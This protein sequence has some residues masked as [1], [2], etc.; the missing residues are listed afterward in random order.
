MSRPEPL[1]PLTMPVPPPHKTNGKRRKNSISQSVIAALTSNISTKAFKT[2]AQRDIPLNTI[3]PTSSHHQDIETPTSPTARASTSSLNSSTKSSYSRSSNP[4]DLQRMTSMKS[5]RVHGRGGHGS[6]PRTI[7]PTPSRHLDAQQ[8]TP[9]RNSNTS[10]SQPSYPQGSGSSNHEI[11]YQ[12]RKAPPNQNK[13]APTNPVP[14]EGD[15]VRLVGRGGLGSKPKQKTVASSSKGK[16][17]QRESSISITHK[18]S[19]LT[20]SRPDPEPVVVRFSGRGGAGSRPRPAKVEITTPPKPTAQSPPNNLPKLRWR[21]RGKRSKLGTALQLKRPST[22]PDLRNP[23]IPAT[24]AVPKA[25]S[26]INND[27]NTVNSFEDSSSSHSLPTMSSMHFRPGSPIQP[28]DLLRQAHHPMTHA[29]GPSSSSLTYNY[30]LFGWPSATANT[31]ESSL[32]SGP[33]EKR[34]DGHSLGKLSKMLGGPFSHP[35]PTNRKPS[36]DYGRGSPL[37]TDRRSESITSSSRM[38]T[39]STFLRSTTS[40]PISPTASQQSCS[41]WDANDVHQHGMES[42]SSL[43]T[44]SSSQLGHVASTMGQVRKRQASPIR[45]SDKL[46]TEAFVKHDDTPDATPSPTPIHFRSRSSTRT[47]ARSRSASRSSLPSQEESPT[48][49]SVVETNLGG[50]TD[51]DNDS[52]T[53]N[54]HG[55]SRRRMRQTWM[56]PNSTATVVEV[57]SKG[58]GGRDVGWVGQWNTDNMQDVI[59]RLRELR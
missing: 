38:E 29:H 21:S 2:T 13:V 16:Q 19:L 58:K 20:V 27:T 6:R 9:P 3:S 32:Y 31:S 45:F 22:S 26:S 52:L 48:V 34:R 28:R 41:T 30:E 10:P 8:T 54:G 36:S 14:V 5:I 43:W 51:D 53:D 50:D 1:P 49:S 40:P 7:T 35:D 47:G 15:V 33:L 23:S 12:S 55:L 57:V 25:R 59:R 24:S 39:L 44:A 4:A 17:P 37:P 42:V 56:V 18:P 46:P 11:E